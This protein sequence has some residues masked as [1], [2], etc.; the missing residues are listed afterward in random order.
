MFHRDFIRKKRRCQ[1]NDN[2]DSAETKLY[3]IIFT[4][5]RQ[6]HSR[7]Q[8]S[9]HNAVSKIAVKKLPDIAVAAYNIFIC[10]KFFQSHGAAGVQFLGGDA[11][12]AA[13]TELATVREAG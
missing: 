8:Y 3:L 2:I 1:Q 4:Q 12:F 10:C 7:R 6:S 13:Q 11:H 5:V 9:T